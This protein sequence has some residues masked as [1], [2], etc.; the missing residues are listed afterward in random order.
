MQKL[1]QGIHA[2][3]THVFR[4]KREL[5]RELA[6]GQKPGAL[7]ITCSDSRVNPNLLTQTEPGEIFIL[8][9]AGN[10]IPPAPVDGGEI[11]TIEFALVALG[12]Q[13]IIVCGHSDCGAM[14][15]VIAPGNVETAMPTVH[16]WL[17]YA[18]RTRDIIESEYKHLKG[19]ELL[20]ATVEEN[21]IVQIENLRTHGFIEER[22]ARGELKLH[23]WVYKFETGEVFS[24]DPESGQFLPLNSDGEPTPTYPRANASG[25]E[26]LLSSY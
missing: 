11:A 25:R 24:Y 3:Q 12:I 20:T 13:D 7:F 10:I 6:N 21:V 9:N 8:R 4:G 2:F 17:R 16:R 15:G 18:H 5:F 14:K 19:C 26:T 1:V 22:L 23:G